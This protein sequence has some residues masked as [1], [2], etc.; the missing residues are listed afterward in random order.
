M[1]V[2]TSGTGRI[3][4]SITDGTV[5]LTMGATTAT[6]IAADIMATNGVVHLI[7]TVM[8]PAE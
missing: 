6:V 4:V 7:D 8:V 2:G 5:T 1:E 3:K